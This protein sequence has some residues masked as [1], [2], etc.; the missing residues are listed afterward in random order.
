MSR[1]LK[2]S[3]NFETKKGLDLK[4]KQNFSGKTEA[5]RKKAKLVFTNFD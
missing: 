2:F 3:D 5:K 1:R 4:L